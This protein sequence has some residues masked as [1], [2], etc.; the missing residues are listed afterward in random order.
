MHSDKV[1]NV[2][3]MGHL[4]VKELGISLRS[5]WWTD[6]EIKLNLD[7]QLDMISFPHVAKKMNTST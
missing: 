3:R 7:F 1:P 6:M 5:C 2:N 4:A